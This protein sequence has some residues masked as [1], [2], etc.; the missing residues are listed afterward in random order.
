MIYEDGR[1]AGFQGIVRDLT[2]RRRADDDLRARVEL[3]HRVLLVGKATARP[4]TI[5]EVI[6]LL[7]DG[8]LRLGGTARAAA[9]L[10][11]PGDVVTC[12]W[13]AGMPDDYV[14]RII[15][16][17]SD[18]SEIAVEIA[19]AA[20]RRIGEAGRPFLCSDVERLSPASM[21]RRAARS[22]GYRAVGVWPLMYGGRLTAL[23]LNYYDA[24]RAWSM[25][26]QDAFEAFCRQGAVALENARLYDAVA[27]LNLLSRKSG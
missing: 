6:P 4:L 13:A 3:M 1:P 8:V 27:Q 26:E 19:G 10:R 21:A 12:P 14:A 9:F 22:A 17:G 15:A 24:A 16:Q 5:G 25:A 2:E 18:L 23:L 11:Q 7:G 20:D